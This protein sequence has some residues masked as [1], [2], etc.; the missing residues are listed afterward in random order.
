[1]VQAAHQGT[2]NI[3]LK[4]AQAITAVVKSE[5]SNGALLDKVTPITRDLLKYWD[6]EGGFA[7]GASRQALEI[8]RLFSFATKTLL[9]T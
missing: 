7:D 1:M 9:H 6:P 5:W 4:L 2:R 8:C 3:P